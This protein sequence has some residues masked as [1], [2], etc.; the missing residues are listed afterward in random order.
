MVGM[1]GNI[2]LAEKMKRVDQVLQEVKI[3][4]KLLL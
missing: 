1:D 4:H 2:S 3:Y